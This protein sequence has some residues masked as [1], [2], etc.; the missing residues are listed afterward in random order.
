MSESTGEQVERAKS[1]LEPVRDEWM[2]RPGVTGIDVGF[3]WEGTRMSEEIGIRV[4]VERLLDLEDVPDG[5][6]FPRYLGDV[7]VQ[8]R[9]EA[10]MGPQDA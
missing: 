3:I 2:R 10:P 7:R 5:E 4:K 1:Q 8:V 9:E 6:L